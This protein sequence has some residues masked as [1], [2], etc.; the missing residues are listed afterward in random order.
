[1]LLLACPPAQL[2]GRGIGRE[3]TVGRLAWC[4]ARAD[5]VTSGGKASKTALGRTAGVLAQECGTQC[6]CALYR[7]FGT[8]IRGSTSST[9]RR[10][11]GAPFGAWCASSALA[12]GRT[13]LLLRLCRGPKELGLVA[14]GPS[15]RRPSAGEGLV[16]A[17]VARPVQAQQ[18]SSRALALASFSILPLGDPCSVPRRASAHRPPRFQ[19]QYPLPGPRLRSLDVLSLR[20]LLGPMAAPVRR[21][22]R[23]HNMGAG[24]WWGP[25]RHRRQEVASECTRA[26]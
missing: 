22:L 6:S 8:D 26:S 15:P 4:C 25:I 9:V 24:S 23:P 10:A 17:Q 16:P 1:M 5:S 20:L 12:L 21:I 2:R 18:L 11:H 3:K 13:V 14:G 7:D 19:Q